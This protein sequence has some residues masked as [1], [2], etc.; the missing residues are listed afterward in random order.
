M[1]GRKILVLFSI[2]MLSFGTSHSI[3]GSDTVVIQH[4]TETVNVCAQSSDCKT[5]YCMNGFCEKCILFGSACTSSN[6]CCQGK[7]CAYGVCGGAEAIMM[8][9]VIA[10]V[11]IFCIGAA[12]VY[13]GAEVG[14]MVLLPEMSMDF[15]ISSD[16]MIWLDMIGWM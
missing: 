15:G 12:I 2:L 16:F 14:G 3:V 5:G 6:E 8:D 4:Q 7:P 10:F 11:L 9:C 13:G 1:S